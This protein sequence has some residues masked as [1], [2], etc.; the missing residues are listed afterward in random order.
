MVSRISKYHR[1]IGLSCLRKLGPHAFY[2]D[3][4]IRPNPNLCGLFIGIKP[5][6]AA[7][8][9][10]TTTLVGRVKEVSETFML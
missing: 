2:R 7:D 10:K 9:K 8:K 1:A 6:L 3:H 4:P 5:G